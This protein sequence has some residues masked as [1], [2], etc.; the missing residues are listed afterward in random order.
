MALVVVTAVLGFFG[1]R[2]LSHRRLR[3]DNATVRYQRFGRVDGRTSVRVEATPTAVTG[4]NVEIWVAQDF[5]E[6]YDVEDVTP[7]PSSTSTRAG[8]VAFSG[9]SR[10]LRLG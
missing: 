9:V 6:A 8:G 2:P 7:E 10:L 1:N 5:L 4:G 3:S